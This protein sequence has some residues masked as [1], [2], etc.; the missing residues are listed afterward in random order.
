MT[1]NRLSTSPGGLKHIVIADDHSIFRIGIKHILHGEDNYHVTAEASDKDELITVLGRCD[2]D[3]VLLDMKMKQ[4]NAGLEA[5]KFIKKSY[6]AVKVVLMSQYYTKALIEDSIK[7]GVDGYITKEDIAQALVFVL[8]SVFAG[9][10]SFSPKV[11]KILMDQI[12]HGDAILEKLTERE[13]EVLRL[14]ADGMKRQEIAES[15]YISV[16]TVDFHKNNIKDK[17]Q[18]DSLADLINMYN[19]YWQ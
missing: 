14:L 9:E 13:R 5:L 1:S 2:C 17:L 8:N 6:P 3:L 7:L 19:K 12:V 15:L 11:Q 16:P 10:K 4:N 18:A